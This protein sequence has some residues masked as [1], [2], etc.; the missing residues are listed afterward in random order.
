MTRALKFSELIAVKNDLELFIDTNL[1]LSQ[2]EKC[3]AVRADFF[4]LAIL[5][6][7]E[8]MIKINLK[9]K[10][11]RK[12]NNL[13]FFAPNSINQIISTSKDTRIHFLAFTSKFLLQAGITMHEMEMLTFISSQYDGAI[14]LTDEEFIRLGKIIEELEIQSKFTN[15]HSFVESI[16]KLQFRVLL[17][18]LAAIGQRNKLSTK[19]KT[20]RKQEIVTGFAKL[21]E[22]HFKEE[23]SLKYYATQLSISTKHLT[24]VVYDVTGKSAGVLIHEK[25]IIEIKYLLGNPSQNIIQISEYLNFPNQSFFGKYFKRYC[26]LSPKEYREKILNG[27]I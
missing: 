16:V 15:R 5:L 18:E 27:A 23:R 2:K 8:V 24:E 19:F 21:L 6:K 7:G 4:S 10:L 1:H 3:K 17:Y 12:K 14:S 25:L 9:E 13:L 20:T 11:T 26:G 22:K